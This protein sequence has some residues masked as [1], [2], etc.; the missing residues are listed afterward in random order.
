MS[1]VT[2]ILTHLDLFLFEFCFDITSEKCKLSTCKNN[3]HIWHWR[4]YFT[5]RNIKFRQHTHNPYTTDYTY[6]VRQLTNSYP[7]S[8]TTTVRRMQ[9]L[10][11]HQ[12]TWE[13][14]RMITEG[15]CKELRKGCMGLA[16]LIFDVAY[17]NLQQA[18]NTPSFMFLTPVNYTTAFL[19]EPE[20]QRTYNIT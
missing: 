10:E 17:G 5:Q 1:L 15:E 13:R 20:R 3:L 6:C 16:D 14:F 18:S 8:C 9:C 19:T 11:P 2:V 12:H 7:C 4:L